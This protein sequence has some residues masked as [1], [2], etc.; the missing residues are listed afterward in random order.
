M[1][2]SGSPRWQIGLVFTL[3]DCLVRHGSQAWCPGTV[4]A[5]PPWEALAMTDPDLTVTL[6]VAGA[7]APELAGDSA[8]GRCHAHYVTL[9][10]RL[11]P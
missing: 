7:E 2:P 8:G 1:T 6:A 9:R 3:P 5:L 11:L 4:S 10:G